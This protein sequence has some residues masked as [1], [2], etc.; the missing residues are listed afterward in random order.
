MIDNRMTRGALALALGA[1][2]L[3]VTAVEASTAASATTPPL[4]CHKIYGHLNTAVVVAKCGVAQ[5]GAH[6]AGT[7]ILSGGTLTWGVSKATTSYTGV[8][9]SPGQGTCIAG[10]VEY[11]FTGT[12]T[13]DTSGY[14]TVGDSVSYHVCINSTTQV[15]KLV[16]GTTGSF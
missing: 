7:D 5:N 15:V 4:V 2:L 10:R 3:G 12:I 14:V 13:A 8:A 9:T 16:N 11:D 1:G 6:F